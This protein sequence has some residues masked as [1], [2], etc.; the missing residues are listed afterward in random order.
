MATYQEKY[1][2]TSCSVQQHG[3]DGLDGSLALLRELVNPHYIPS[4]AGG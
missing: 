1:E 4:D 3:A 2:E